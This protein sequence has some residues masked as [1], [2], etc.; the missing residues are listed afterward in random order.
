MRLLAVLFRPVVWKWALIT[1]APCLLLMALLLSVQG[2]G[3]WTRSSIDT[4]ERFQ[5]SFLDIDCSVPPNLGRDQFLVEVKDL[6]GIPDHF[7]LVADDTPLLLKRS[8]EQHPWV[9]VVQ[10]VDFPPGRKIHVL[11][12][13]RTP[14]LAVAVAGTRRIVDEQCVLLPEMIETPDLPI[15]VSPVRPPPSGPGT[16]WGDPTLLEAV[17]TV[18]FLNEV[19]DLP[20]FA[21]VQRYVS[22]LVFTTAE[23]ARVYWGQP[24]TNRA[25]ASRK[26]DRLRS[27]CQREGGLDH[28]TTGIHD[29]TAMDQP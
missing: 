12:Q 6:S 15:Y 26:R 5:G 18:V 25:T 22:G 16:R 14:T 8:F 20:R 9:R 19:K 3:R 17:Q 1:L 24:A 23:G 21:S 2:L 4:A 27:L 13:F 28:S 7:S 29:L 11:L 10:K